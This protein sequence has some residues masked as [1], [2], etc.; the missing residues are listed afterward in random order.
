M[1]LSLHGKVFIIRGDESSHSRREIDEGAWA[2]EGLPS[3]WT[4]RFPG[5]TGICWYRI[6]VIFPEVIPDRALGLGLGTISDVDEVYFN[7]HLIGRTGS[8]PPGRI[9]AYDRQRVYEIPA[10]LVRPGGDNVIAV[11]VAGLFEYECGL[12]KGPFRVDG[13]QVL[14][15]ELLINGFVHVLLTVIYLVVAFY[16]GLL[17]IRGADDREY[18]FFSLFTISSAAYLFLRTQIK[19]LLTGDFMLLKRIEYLVLFA[20]LPFMMEYF[21]YFFRKRHGALHYACYALAAAGAAAV[22]F[23]D[24]LRF[25]ND[26]LFFLVEP[27]WI[28]PLGYCLWISVRELGRH[29]DAR[30]VIA[31]FPL[32]WIVFLNDVLVDRGVLESV[33]LSHYGFLVVIAGTAFIMRRRFTELHRKAEKIDARRLNRNIGTDMREK[34]DRVIRYIEENYTEDISREGIAAAVGVHHDYL[35]KMFRDYTGRKIG[36][37]ISELRVSRAAG[38]LLE[39][40]EPVT[41]IAFRV[42][43][44]SLSTFYRAFQKYRGDSPAGY[45]EKAAKKRTS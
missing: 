29:P 4:R 36:D 43:F 26:V 37:Y 34:L 11:R 30:Y 16:F 21:T 17:Y 18:L 14:Q 44:E 31:A 2:E 39:G 20:I 8:F 45:R 41:D 22:L 28:I 6:H 33:R 15:R 10:R 32:L 5:W 9:S 19:Y 7:G 40:D 23:S 25:W 27:S 3:N 42:G 1:D 13:L 24:D 35:G 12:I 38:M